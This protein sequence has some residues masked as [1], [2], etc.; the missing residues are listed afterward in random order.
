MNSLMSRPAGSTKKMVVWQHADGKGYLGGD[1]CVLDDFK[2][3]AIGGV[4]KRQGWTPAVR[5][6]G[7]STSLRN[8]S[9]SMTFLTLRQAA[10]GV[11]DHTVSS[12]SES[13]F[14]WTSFA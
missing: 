13:G 2:S 7:I 8:S 3:S 1:D 14:V 11:H 5:D 10:R 6:R 12:I 4:L 9:S